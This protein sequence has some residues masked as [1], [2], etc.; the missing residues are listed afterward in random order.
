MVGL[1]TG[2]EWLTV[3]AGTNSIKRFTI[4]KDSVT[5]LTLTGFALTS[6]GAFASFEGAEGETRIR[7]LAILK[8]DESKLQ[9]KWL[10]MKDTVHDFQTKGVPSRLLGSYKDELVYTTGQGR[11]EW[12]SVH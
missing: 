9:C 1:Y 11:I 12:A 5:S 3:T 8:C 4:D 2:S 7:G 10:P 6:V